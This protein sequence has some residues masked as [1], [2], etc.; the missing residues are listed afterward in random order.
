METSRS[1]EYKVGVFIAIALAMTLAIIIALGGNTSL[2]KNN[3][4]FKVRA[5][6]TN[7]LYVGAVVQV[8]GIPAGNI[9]DI[10]FDN[11]ANSIVI[12][13]TVETTL[14]SRLTQGSKAGLKTQGALG[15]KFINITPGPRAVQPRELGRPHGLFAVAASQV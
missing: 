6:E 11:D 1:M 9:K 14:A 7:G 15:D 8:S 5:D 2:F 4:I 3:T 13:I 10:S 12:S